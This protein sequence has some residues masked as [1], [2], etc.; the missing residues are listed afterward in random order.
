MIPHIHRE[1]YIYHFT[2][3]SNLPGI[4]E[5]GFLSKN[6]SNFPNEAVK[7]I[8]E[9][10]IQD[11]RSKMIVPCGPGGCVHDY[12]PLYFGSLS[13]MLLRVVNEKNVDQSDILYFEFSISIL[14][15]SNVVF[16][17]SS[18]NAAVPP[19]FYDDCSN[20][21][22]LNWNEI[23]SRKWSSSSDN[24]RHQR[25][26][27]ALVRDCLPVSAASRC[28]VWNDEIK[29][30]VEGIVAAANKPFPPIDFQMQ[31]RWHWFTN[32]ASGGKSSVVT[33]PRRI[34]HTFDAACEEIS[35]EHSKHAASA[36]FP[37]LGKMLEGLRADFGCLR[38]PQSSLASNR[39][40]VSISI[41]WIYTPNR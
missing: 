12:V 32:F 41:R 27:E 25:M 9:E 29:K 11:R 34:R 17:D 3:I 30:T 20:L 21:D 5:N 26:A 10:G 19:N 31:G 23:D 6:N 15:N 7:S 36:P 24:L 28:V 37:K 4:L 33:G 38:K 13:P 2:H 16:T 40:T 8:A 14:E 22:K 39:R 35:K 1:R 18:A